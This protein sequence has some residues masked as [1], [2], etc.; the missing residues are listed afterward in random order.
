MN[1]YSGSGSSGMHSP[2]GGSING[3]APSPP[4]AASS[5]I[6]QQ[7]PPVSG[8]RQLSKLKRFLTTLIQFGMDISVE[9]GERVR[10]LVLALVV[11]KYYRYC[12]I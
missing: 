4:E 12:F 7:L 8:A 1:T 3:L 5:L 11:S 9:I 2:H 10:S 6:S